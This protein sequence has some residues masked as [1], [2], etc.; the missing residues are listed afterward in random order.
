M[1]GPKSESFSRFESAPLL[2]VVS[3]SK[4]I[5]PLRRGLEY[6]TL[7]RVAGRLATYAGAV[8]TRTG[9]PREG[10]EARHAPARRD[11]PGA[12]CVRASRH[13][14]RYIPTPAGDAAHPRL[15][16][17]PGRVARRGV[18]VIG[19]GFGSRSVRG[20]RQFLSRRVAGS[21]ARSWSADHDKKIRFCSVPDMC[22]DRA[23]RR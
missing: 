15:A 22:R 18:D 21:D 5:F 7:D 2:L 1:L 20:S 3:L 9:V 10:R 11:A 17:H 13:A 23:S 8:A 4:Y 6:T 16:W 19:S 14:W 12:P